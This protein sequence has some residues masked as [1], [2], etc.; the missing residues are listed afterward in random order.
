MRKLH[1]VLFV[2]LYT[3][4]Y[5]LVGIYG[6]P[7][8]MTYCV[9]ANTSTILLMAAL[10]L[11]VFALIS[12]L[13]AWIVRHTIGLQCGMKTLLKCTIQLWETGL[14]FLPAALI[15]GGICGLAAIALQKLFSGV[16]DLSVIKILIDLI[17]GTLTLFSLPV[18]LHFSISSVLQ[19]REI[20][21]LWRKALGSLKKT[22]WRI[23]AAVALSALA[24]GIITF[25]L[26]IFTGML[27]RIL[28]LTSVT[29]IGTAAFMWI[30]S[31]YISITR[32]NNSCGFVERKIGKQAAQ[33]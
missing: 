23:F 21:N 18:F 5:S 10:V 19:R 9:G 28:Q 3:V 27:S 15:L 6:V 4:L 11:M 30:L 2:F 14:I 22:Y 13:Y 31:R 25:I 20:R 8:F 12:F 16:L 1:A 32:E 17:A 26:S 24:Q 29:L 7:W 33:S